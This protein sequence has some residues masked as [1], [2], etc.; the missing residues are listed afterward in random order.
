MQDQVLHFCLFHN[1]QPN[2]LVQTGDPTGSGEGGESVYKQLFGEQ[3]T[4]FD[5]EI[6]P[7]LRHTRAGCVSMASARPN[8]NASQFFITVAA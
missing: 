4:F 1:V 2:S 6:H 8:A 5:D 7:R 3:A